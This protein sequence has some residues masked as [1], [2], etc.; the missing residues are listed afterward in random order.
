MRTNNIYAVVLKVAA[1]DHDS[2]HYAATAVHSSTQ[3]V[4]VWESMNINYFQR[5]L[6]V[7][8]YKHYKLLCKIL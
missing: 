1:T 3:I 8:P 6:T 2:K 4:S 7:P 5:I